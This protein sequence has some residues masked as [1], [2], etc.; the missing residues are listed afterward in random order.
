MEKF[1]CFKNQDYNK[2]KKIYNEKKLFEDPLFPAASSSCFFSREAPTKWVWKRPKEINKNAQFVINGFSRMDITQG[3]LGDCYFIAACIG[4][5]QSE[6]LFSRVVPKDQ[7]FD[8]NYTGMFHF[9]FYEY[10]EWVDVVV[11]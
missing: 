9:R 1:K 6:K 10:G 7:N 5:V 4:L 3:C 2:L 11:R 8:K